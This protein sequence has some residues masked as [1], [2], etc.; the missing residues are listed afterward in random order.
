LSYAHPA[1]KSDLA[2][3][4]KAVKNNGLVVSTLDYQVR[5]DESIMSLAV[6]QD[7]H[8]LGYAHISLQENKKIVLQAIRKHP[9]AL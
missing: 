9:Y 8:Y 6:Q 7:G 4:K 3:V 1:F 5:K 2:L